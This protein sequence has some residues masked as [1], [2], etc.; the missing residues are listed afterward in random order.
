MIFEIRLALAR[1]VTTALLSAVMPV[2]VDKQLFFITIAPGTMF[3]KNSMFSG[4]I[5]DG[6]VSSSSHVPLDRSL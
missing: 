4:V 1:D 3:P 6:I 2:S 5:D